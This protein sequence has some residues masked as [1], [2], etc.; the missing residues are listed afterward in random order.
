MATEQ[1]TS[2]LIGLGYFGEGT[3]ITI[4]R[5]RMSRSFEFDPDGH[6]LVQ[7]LHLCP[8]RLSGLKAALFKG[9]D[10]PFMFVEC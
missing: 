9:R 1:K 2:D 6:C 8:C 5:R 7:A 3:Y 10:S 4:L